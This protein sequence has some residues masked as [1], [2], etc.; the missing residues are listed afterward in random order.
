MREDRPPL[1]TKGVVRLNARFYR[2]VSFA[3][4]DT[5]FL[6]LDFFD[7]VGRSYSLK[8]KVVDV[9]KL[10]TLLGGKFDEDVESKYGKLRLVRYFMHK[11]KELSTVLSFKNLGEL[12]DLALE[13]DA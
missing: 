11:I 2:F 3:A 10:A 5:P 7:L 4:E 8:N 12:I 13:V 6:E 9:R 1:I